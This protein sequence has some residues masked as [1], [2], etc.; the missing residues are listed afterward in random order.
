MWKSL[1]KRG[2]LLL[3]LFVFAVCQPMHYAHLESASQAD[4]SDIENQDMGE[5]IP[6]RSGEKEFKETFVS[7]KLDLVFVLDT[8]PEMVPFYQTG[9]FGA[10]FLD[11]FQKYDWRL[12]YTDMSVDITIFAQSQSQE[13][14]KYQKAE[15]KKDSCSFFSGLIMTTGGFFTGQ[16]L[17]S[18]FGINNLF[19]CAARAI[20]SNKKKKTKKP[21]FTNGSFLPFEYKGK[22]WNQGKSLFLT[23]STPNY[24]EIFHHTMKPGSGG[25]KAA[26][27][28]PIQKDLEAYPFLSMILSMA[29]EGSIQTPQQ[30]SK[31][32]SFFRKDSVIKYVLITSSDF[33]TK[34]DPEYFKDSVKSFFGSE[35]RLQIIPV[36]V[37]SDA[38]LVCQMK[39]KQ[40]PLPNKSSKM[41]EFVT[42]LDSSSVL[43]IC[44]QNLAEELFKEISKSLYP[45][46]FLSD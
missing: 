5:K 10:A 12:A 46:G 15:E 42:E 9:L 18:S 45:T 38:A 19:N 41:E 17:I 32:E 39:F 36:T 27:D 13:E 14:E 25:K 8:K 40:T 16:P 3:S 35:K 30:S 37:K 31:E 44:S 22:K 29:K 43:N 6:S 21:I 23:N 34:I 20:S 33:Q 2:G 7:D 11:R 26:Y 24:K 1:I 28:P 4:L